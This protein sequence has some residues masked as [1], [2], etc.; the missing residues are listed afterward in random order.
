MLDLFFL[1]NMDIEAL[2]RLLQDHGSNIPLVMLT[3]TNNAGGGQ[4]VSVGNIKFV[5]AICRHYGKPLYLD[6]CR[7]VPNTSFRTTLFNLFFKHTSSLK[8]SR[9]TPTT[10]SV[11]K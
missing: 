4:P 7:S 2:E 1:G 11:K 6:A 3:L 9:G 8:E 5:S 10:K